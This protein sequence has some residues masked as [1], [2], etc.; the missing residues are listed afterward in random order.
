MPF[1]SPLF[2]STRKAPDPQA[3]E[4]RGA[5]C[6]TPRARGRALALIAGAALTGV[7]SALC[8]APLAHGGWFQLLP[9]AAFFFLLGRTRTLGLALAAGLAFGF[10]LF[11]K[12]VAWLYISLHDYG[13]MPAPLAASAVLLFS[14]YLGLY[15]ALAAGLWHRLGR[16][17]GSAPG[18]GGALRGMLWSVLVFAA[19]WAL[20]EWLRGT[21]FTGFPWLALGYAQVDGPTAG[22]AA[23][24]G[25][26][27]V[28]MAAVAAAALLSLAAETACRRN[29]PLALA[30]LAA[31]VSLALVVALGQAVRFTHAD[32]EPISVRLLQGNVAQSMK[33]EQAGVDHALALYRQLITAAPADLIVTPETALPLLTTQI[34]ED[35]FDAL[36]E[37]STR[38]HSA[39]LLGAVGVVRDGDRAGYTNSMLG[40]APAAARLYRY[41]KHHLVPFGEFVPWGFRWFVDLMN[42][43][44]G[45]F[46]RGAPVQPS[47]AVGAHRIAVDICYED[48]FGEEIART[49]RAA[50]EPATI[51]VNATN[52]AWFGNTVALDQHLQIA[53]MRSLETQRPM[54]RATNTGATA[55]IDAHGRVLASLPAFT[56]G[57]LSVRLEG[58]R[59]FTPYVRWGNAPLLI[60]C[61]ALLL[62]ALWRRGWRGLRGR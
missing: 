14:L 24:L 30:L 54:L 45:D 61:V 23:F 2:L 29:A 47:F 12:G 36:R 10:G 5:S 48:I 46:D 41:D 8:F 53:R 27:G 15:P 3:G 1:I 17:R 7:A 21:V 26:Y 31:L 58:T 11:A 60:G 34:P 62:L 22:V 6:R 40:V 32:G 50:A 51:M 20:T 56:V 16:A 28:G 4:A 52:L 59:G 38:T 37:F 55:A 35:F 13:G 9:L 39:L 33:F 43:P 42:I 25:V 19:A 44:L 49:L 18:T 57:A